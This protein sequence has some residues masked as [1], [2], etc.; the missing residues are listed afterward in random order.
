[1]LE[2]PC[3][4]SCNNVTAYFKSIGE[5]S[6]KMEG[7]K[8]G[9][10]PLYRLDK[11]VSGV[12]L[13]A[14][15]SKDL[16]ITGKDYYLVCVGK[17]EASGVMEDLLYHDKRSNRVFPVKRMRK[18]VKEARLAYETLAYSEA[19]DLSF[20]K[21]S[22]DTGR[23]HQIRVQFASRKMPLAGDGKYGSRIKCDIALIC[24]EVRFISEGREYKASVDLPDIYPWDLFKNG[25]SYGE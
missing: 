9:L 8:E 5:D 1:M 2:R 23:T 10:S 18:G 3:I 12:M 7:I 22:L 15:S 21:V 16:V 6:E 14:G 20:V 24:Q 17:T 11:P 13:F 4:I 25:G 19:D